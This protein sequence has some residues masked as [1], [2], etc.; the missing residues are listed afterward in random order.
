MFN[1]SSRLLLLQIFNDAN[2]H[3]QNVPALAVDT[4]SIPFMQ[5]ETT[6]ITG[7]AHT[8]PRQDMCTCIMAGML[9]PFPPT[10]KTPAKELMETVDHGQK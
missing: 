10:Q 5:D 4:V 1:A 2:Y 3:R 9:I 7:N 8:L 6:A